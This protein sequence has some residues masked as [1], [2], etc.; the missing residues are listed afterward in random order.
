L[1]CASR[2]DF[3]RGK[4]AAGIGWRCLSCMGVRDLGKV[5]LNE[6]AGMPG[7]F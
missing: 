7:K 3:G 6:E 5:R 2:G 1:R 4:V